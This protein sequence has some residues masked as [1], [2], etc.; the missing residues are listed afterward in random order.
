M[1]RLVA[2]VCLMMVTGATVFPAA[3]QSEDMLELA[4]GDRR[5]TSGAQEW[6]DLIDRSELGRL[7]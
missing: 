3:G 2:R 1:F 5:P 7:R 6:S 4:V